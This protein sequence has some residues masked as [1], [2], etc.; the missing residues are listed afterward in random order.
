MDADLTRAPAV[1]VLMPVFNGERYLREAVTSILGQS[2]RDFE[3]LIVDD[4]STD[5]SAAIIEELKRNDSRVRS[6]FQ[7]N[8]GHVAALNAGL[9]SVRGNYIARMDADDVAR[10]GRLE[11]QV[12]FL[13]NHPDIGVV[14]TAATLIDGDGRE[15]GVVRF[16]SSH[17][18]V[19]WA[20]CFG[21][22]IIHPSAMI[23]ADVLR[24]AGGYD[25]EMRHA[26]DYDLWLRISRISRLAN[27]EEPLLLL[28]KHG[29]NV[30][31][32]SPAD[33]RRFSVHVSR[34]AMSDVLGEQVPEALVHQVWDAGPRT[35]SDAA[36]VAH[37]VYRLYD[38][39]RRQTTLTAAEHAAI[40]RDAA[41]RLHDLARPH[42][43]RPAL[44]RS[45]LRAYHLD[46][47]LLITPLRRRL[48]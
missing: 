3:L 25:A 32:R 21:S 16:P 33:E 43:R 17:G 9:E 4:G 2:F 24:Q 10:P 26:E 38:A 11:A 20:L 22:P 27:L 48:T 15:S 7:S 45:L 42:V 1:T 40:R 39:T 30:S 23:R 6:R 46:I 19:R 34:A 47:S 29:G 5:A 8:Q 35:A 31:E 28:R 14:G 37:L 41:R 36:D 18:A 12:R 44:Y 13:E